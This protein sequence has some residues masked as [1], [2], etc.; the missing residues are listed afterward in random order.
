MV[1]LELEKLRKIR[2]EKKG[3]FLR[4]NLGKGWI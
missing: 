1:I 2:E 3:N 4:E